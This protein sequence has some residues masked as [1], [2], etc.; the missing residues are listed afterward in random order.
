MTHPSVQRWPMFSDEDLDFVVGTVVRKRTDHEHI[1]ELLRDKPDLVDI[2]LDDDRLADRVLNEEDVFVKITPYLLFSVLLRH[3]YRTMSRQPYTYEIIGRN[4]RVPIFDAPKVNNLLRNAALRDYLAELLSSFTRA[5]S[6]TVTVRSGG[7]TYQRCISSLDL[8]TLSELAESVEEPYRFPIYKR[9]GDLALFLA[10]IF[11]EYVASGRAL[12]TSRGRVSAGV[13]SAAAG[14]AA[15]VGAS[16]G[17][18]VS[19]SGPVLNNSAVEEE[20]KK[21]YELAAN[22]YGAHIAELEDILRTLAEN[23]TLAKKPLNLLAERYIRLD[24]YDWF[25][26]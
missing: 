4:E 10:G 15:A 12:L 14:A 3:A 1:R 19:E 24:R 9:M 11:P 5:E 22:H 20:G 8:A 7:K 18:V 13:G 23:F 25:L 17:G 21:F 6:R 26:Q 16:G 2:M